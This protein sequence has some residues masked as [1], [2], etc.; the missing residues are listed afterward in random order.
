MTNAV[1]EDPEDAVIRNLVALNDYLGTV[2]QCVAWQLARNGDTLPAFFVIP[3]PADADQLQLAHD[4]LSDYMAL[5]FDN[6]RLPEIRYHG[7][8]HILQ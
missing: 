1:A 2:V 4:M 3:P 6:A 7:F 8:P 5:E